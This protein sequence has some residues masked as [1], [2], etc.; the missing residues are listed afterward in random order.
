MVF[1]ATV[2]GTGI[3]QS[4]MAVPLITE[5]K[6]AAILDI[7][8]LVAWG[9]G[10][11]VMFRGII[12]GST[13][14]FAWV[15]VKKRMPMGLAVAGQTP[16]PMREGNKSYLAFGYGNGFV[17]NPL[18]HGA[19]GSLMSPDGEPL[20]S[21]NSLSVFI[22]SR[23]P[24]MDRIEGANPGGFLIGG[25]ATHSA[26]H[27]PSTQIRQWGLCIGRGTGLGRARMLARGDV[28]D[29]P[30]TEA[31]IDDRDGTWHAYGGIIDDK[32]KAVSLLR[33][34]QVAGTGTLGTQTISTVA[35]A[36]ELR[37]GATGAPGSPPD[38]TF[39]GDIL[40]WALFGTAIAGEDLE[41]VNTWTAWAKTL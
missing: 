11:Q 41:T 19:N 29:A 33:D 17:G 38:F 2:R 28:S 35:G 4:D 1:N 3:I 5:D 16:K 39:M 18:S 40:C 36:R 30:T 7:P 21:G 6:E 25:K 12:T 10:N 15:D 31:T 27:N 24:V 34:E 32:A 22:V 37:L 14:P 20:F 26:T 13:Q 8:S 23:V 9:R